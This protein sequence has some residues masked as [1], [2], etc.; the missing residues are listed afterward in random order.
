M[1]LKTGF[2]INLIKQDYTFLLDCWNPFKNMSEK[3]K[4]L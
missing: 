1:I 3:L 2:Y 4:A